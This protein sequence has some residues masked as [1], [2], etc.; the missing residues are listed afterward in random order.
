MVVFIRRYIIQFL[1]LILTGVSLL[2]FQTPDN[3]LH[4]IAC[5]V[6]QGDAI[7][8]TYKNT[9]ILTDGGPNDRVLDCLSEHLPLWDR[10]IELVV[11]THPDSDHSTGLVEVINRYEVD[12]ILINSLNPGTQVYKALESA[13]GSRGVRVV[14]PY[15][16][17]ALGLEMIHLDI[18]HPDEGF[19]DP[20]TNQYSIAYILDY[21]DFEAIFTGDFEQKISDSLANN[22][23]LRSVE[24]IKVPHH[25]S[26]NGLTENLL[27]ALEPKIAV[28]S[29]GKN[30]PYKHPHQEILDMLGKYNVKILRTDE[31]GDVEIISDGEGVWIN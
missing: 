26:R 10:Q 16:G 20:K 13:I 29:V 25:G 9:Q 5:D 31:M 2:V 28:I 17:M 8:V 15:E 19:E 4:I 27:K 6:G 11:S 3:Y 22:Y 24:Y 7:L 14:N 1:I 30:N 12:T 23:L 21:G 18:L